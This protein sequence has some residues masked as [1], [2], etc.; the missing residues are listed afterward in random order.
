MFYFLTR[1]YVAPPA[2][3]PDPEPPPVVPG[4]ITYSSNV[5]FTVPNYNVLTIKMWGGGGGGGAANGNGENG[6]NGDDSYCTSLGLRAGGGKGG[7]GCE[8]SP[9]P[10]FGITG[11]DGGKATGFTAASATGGDGKN[12]QRGRIDGKEG[13]FWNLSGAGG[14]ATGDLG[15]T[16]GGAKSSDNPGADGN[17]A[18]GGG[19]GGYYKAGNDSSRRAGA[20]GGAGAYGR[21]VYV[22]GAGGSPAVGASLTFVVGGKGFGGDASNDKQGGDGAGGRIRVEWS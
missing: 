19:S 2:P 16:G 13:D 7:K 14:D 18:G 12:A 21:Q 11:G 9:L 8:E 5:T 1:G 4:G 20:G 22:K 6:T 10:L 17:A 15:G 3:D